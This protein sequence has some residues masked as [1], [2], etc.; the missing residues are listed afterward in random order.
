M[1]RNPASVPEVVPEHIR[2]ALIELNLPSRYEPQFTL[3]SL[4][5]HRVQV[6]DESNV[7]PADMVEAMKASMQSGVQFPPIVVTADGYYV[8]GNTRGKAASKLSWTFLPAVVLDAEW[9]SGDTSIQSKLIVLGARLNSHHGKP[10]SS[11]ERRKAMRS[12]VEMNATTE[13]IMQDL[14]LSAKVITPLRQAIAAEDKLR[15]CGLDPATF[16]DPLLKS[17]GKLAINLNSE[18]FKQLA[19][20]ALDAA[21]NQSDVRALV[22]R[23]RESG[24]DVAALAIITAE[25]DALAERISQRII[26]G[27]VGPSI[28]HQLRMHLGFILDRQ[29]T[30]ERMV[31]GSPTFA[32]AH[33]ERITE[34]IAVLTAVLRIQ[35]S[36]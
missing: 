16:T 20:L 19:Q 31:E 11:A 10:L 17:L 25:R 21:L 7:A 34:A 26:T 29:A 2:R 36:Q 5:G 35:R 23:M 28:P 24:S 33:V 18:P 9:N 27:T 12:M 3:A 22:E 4:N 30:P 32:D 14:G 13:R 15:R 8:D 1:P 6:R